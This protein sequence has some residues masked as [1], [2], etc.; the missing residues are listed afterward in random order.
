MEVHV[1]FSAAD[2]PGAGGGISPAM[3]D[4]AVQQGLALHQRGRLQEATNAYVRVLT[5]DP[6][7]AEANHLLGLALHQSGRNEE[8]ALRIARA[9]QRVPG[10]AVYHSNLG[11]VLKVL[12]RLDEAAQSYERSL[13]LDPGQAQVHSNLGVALLELGRAEEA[14]AAQEQALKLMPNYAEAH[15]SLGLALVELGHTDEAIERYRRAIALRPDY[16]N[17]HNNLAVAFAKLGRMEEARQSAERAVAL[18]P[19]SAPMHQ[20]LGTI[21]MEAGR[22]EEALAS[23]QKAIAIKPDSLSYAALGRLLGD[24]GRSNEAGEAL[25][26]A[27]AAD[28]SDASAYVALAAVLR[29]HGNPE[30]AIEAFSKAAGLTPGDAD[31][32]AGLGGV[33]MAVGRIEEAETACRV[34]L[35][36]DPDN[37]SARSALMFASNYRETATIDSI[38]A[39]A[40]A[41]GAAVGRRFTARTDFA[42]RPDPAKRLK[43]GFV[44][45][46]LYAHPVARFLEGVLPVIDTGRLEL[47]A[48]SLGP[49]QDAVT[50]RLKP[51]FAHWQTAV[52]MTEGQ[53]EA[54]ILADGIDILVDLSGHTSHNRLLVFAR[55]PAPVTVTWLGYSGTT[56][57]G[58]IDYILADRFV[59]PPVAANQFTEAVWRMPDSYL[60][61]SPPEAPPVATLPALSNGYVTFGSFNNINKLSRATL[62]LW[63]RVL[64]ALPNSRLLIKN[65]P[66]DT[67]ATAD[68]LRAAFAA[69][70]ADAS[71]IELVGFIKEGAGHMGA[72]GRIDIGLDPFPYNGTTTTCEALWMGVPVLT[73]AGDRF[74][75]RVGESLLHSAGL[76]DWV[77]ASEDDYVAKAVRFAADLRQL[78]ALRASLRPQM[79]ASPLCDAPRFAA[80]LEAAFRGMWMAW[81]EARDHAG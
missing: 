11:V 69:A 57:V 3:L 72:Y 44:S 71:R 75:A 67:P 25:V 29:D 64:E 81:C 35:V 76:P 6:E 79:A 58:A 8:A 66:L 14:A 12:N 48:Y 2:G 52:Y 9:T 68:K 7:H 19:N 74:I 27:I 33:L 77:A 56:G 47:F 43:V 38:A 73:L 59:A 60:C 24:L 36:L 53:L 55:K 4:R 62:A 50:E 80:N 20:T 28:P 45:G 22:P 1:L 23:F 65:R 63:A 32:H 54:Q 39:E 46:D 15:A 31:V 51:G 30:G 40:R 34:A 70:G 21:L 16:A 78:A 13:R 17:A 42:N 10:N 18:R 49:K 41:F 61:F 37:L 5:I 26:A